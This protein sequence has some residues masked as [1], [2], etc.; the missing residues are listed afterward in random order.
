[1]LVEKQET[2]DNS[3]C[4]PLDEGQVRF[5]KYKIFQGWY[6]SRADWRLSK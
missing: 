6:M 5:T 3:A 2:R 4:Q 1:M